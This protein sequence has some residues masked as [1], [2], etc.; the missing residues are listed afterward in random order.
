MKH[1]NYSIKDYQ[2][3][4]FDC[5]GVIL[6]SNKIKTQAFYE[7]T[8]HFGHEPAQTL[9]DYH[10]QNGGIS[11][12]AKFEYFLTKILKQPITQCELDDLLARFANAVKSGLINCEI[13]EG[14]ESL[15]AACPSAN[16]LIVSGGDQLELREVFSA[17]NLDHLFDGGI[18]GSPDTKDI[19]L[20][21]EEMAL[22]I[23]RPALFIGDSKYDYLAAS[24]AQIDFVF[25][26]NWTEIINWKVWCE[27]HNLQHLSALKDLELCL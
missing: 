11:R 15:K 5:D 24:N 7:A 21:R 6:N 3:L 2:T 22:N 23:R 13:A 27:K 4:V 14:L 19:I 20:S 12:Y 18:F 1:L 26:S 9:V 25:M 17:R 16:W 8:K 10:V